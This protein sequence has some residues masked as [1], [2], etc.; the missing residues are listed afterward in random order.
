MI[1]TDASVN[2]GNSGGP[3][4]NQKAEVLGI[5]RYK[6]GGTE[7]LN[8]AIPVNYLHGMLEAPLTPMSLDEVRAKLAQKTDV[9]KQGEGFP[10]R[11]KSLD[12][13]TTG[14]IR[15]DGDHMYVEVVVPEAAKQ[16]GEFAIADLKRRGDSYSG[17]VRQGIICRNRLGAITNR[18]SLEFQVELTSVTATRIEG[19]TIDRPS[20]AKFNCAKGT[21]SKPSVRTPFAWIPE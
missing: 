7:N 1:Q 21:W 15:L 14:A 18:F 3:L 10:S 20:D 13:D 5:I 4:V 12:S 11:W 8:F 19:W 6:I 16:A 17:T 2:P 9:F